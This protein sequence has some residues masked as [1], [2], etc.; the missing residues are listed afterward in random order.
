MQWW[1]WL[2]VGLI[3]VALE[4]AA[5]GGFYV[6]FFG[7]AAIVI[8]SL[9]ALGLAG[10]LWVQFLLFSVLSVLS[11]VLFRSPLLRL[12]KLDGGAADV[13][14][15]VGETAVPLDDIAP[16]AVG[17]AEL[18]GTVWAARNTSKSA[19]RRG[20]RCRVVR[21]DRLMIFLEPEGAR[22]WTPS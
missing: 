10:P 11:L 22:A 5:S 4:M 15:L 6:I 1:H 13:D 2:A 21:V 9:H 12:M 8:G 16:D 3:L 19:L 18:R 17:R 20:E 14:S 7:V